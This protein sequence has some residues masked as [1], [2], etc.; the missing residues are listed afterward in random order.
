M[1]SND[2][3]LEQ[4]KAD[5]APILTE[6]RDIV[7][8]SNVELLPNF[9]YSPAYA[10]MFS[11]EKRLK[12]HIEEAAG[13]KL[14][15]Y[16][17]ALFGADGVFSE[18]LSNAFVHGHRRDPDVAIEITTT[19]GL[20]G[21]AF[22]ISDQGVGFEVES[23]V[24]AALTGGSYFNYAGNG[25]RALGE[26]TDVIA[27]YANYGRTLNLNVVLWKKRGIRHEDS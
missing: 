19:V 15:T 16:E 7:V 23:T 8:P 4:L 26:R 1:I 2:M 18:G 6:W 27:V 17:Q 11:Y 13:R 24:A 9:G 22:S 21:L 14:G 3:S 12:Y 20:A 25:L 5:I 10:W